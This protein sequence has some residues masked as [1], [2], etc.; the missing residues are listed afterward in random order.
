MQLHVGGFHGT[1]TL[2]VEPVS[3]I[4][5]PFE[6]N[7]EKFPIDNAF[8]LPKINLHDADPTQLNSICQSY[9]HLKEIS[10]PDFSDNQIGLIL[11]QD[12]FDL[13][14]AK[15]VFKGPDNAPRA[16]LTDIGWTIGGP[17][18]TS[19][20]LLSFQAPVYQSD[21]QDKD[22]YD[23]IATFW[24]MDTYGTSPEV[25]MSHDEKHALQTLEATTRY[26]DGA[27][28][29]DCFGSKKRNCRIISTQPF[30]NSKDC[31]NV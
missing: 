8:V 13:I 27:T 11:G 4:L 10:F 12:N 30:C 25:T 5:H 1:K 21:H 20:E 28:R 29:L 16:V 31:K 2:T 14:T 9:S 23:L 6:Q 24:R 19:F 3:F 15:A 18:D 22:L 26:V 7:A 17:N